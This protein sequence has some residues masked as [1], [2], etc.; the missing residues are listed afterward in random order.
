MALGKKTGGRSKGSVN[1]TTKE[2]KE[3]LVNFLN[4][5][6]IDLQD[7][8]SELPASEKIK[9]ILQLAKI[10]IPNNSVDEVENTYNGTQFN[11]KS[12]EIVHTTKEFDKQK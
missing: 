9:V 5:I 6:T 7:V 8:Y 1:R 4:D 3:T 2:A 11:I 12:I 10:L